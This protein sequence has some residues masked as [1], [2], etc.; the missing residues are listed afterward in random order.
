MNNYIPRL[1]SFPGSPHSWS[2]SVQFSCSV[3]VNGTQLQKWVKVID[4]V[5]VRVRVKIGLG[6]VMVRVRIRLRLD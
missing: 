1:A 2:V 4:L 5:R 6:M 3:I